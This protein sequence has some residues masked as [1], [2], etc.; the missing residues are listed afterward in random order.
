[1]FSSIIS[2]SKI[3]RVSKKTIPILPFLIILSMAIAGYSILNSPLDYLQKDSVRIMYIHVPC[4]WFA[5]GL[6][7]SM[8]GFALGYVITRNTTLHYIGVSIA[9]IGAMLCGLCLV[10]GSIWGK[11][12]WGTWW[13]WDARLTSMLILF[14]M[15]L[16]YIS[17]YKG[18]K[19]NS[20]KAAM[21]C[22]L[23]ALVGLVNIPIIKFSVEIWSTLHQPASI[24]KIG[25]PTVHASMLYPLLFSTLT[26]FLLALLL[27][28]MR[29][30]TLMNQLRLERLRILKDSS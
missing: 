5:L 2:A 11:P 15:Y 30:R 6:Y 1:M 17:L 22:S 23:I 28:L 18:S 20:H 26:I 4:A 8:A 7:S 29:I 19:L 24:F 3:N 13:V 10:T 9:P 16:G 27:I 25:G 21:N 12:T 14:L